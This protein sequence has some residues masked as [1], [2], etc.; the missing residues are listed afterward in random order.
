MT[1]EFFT[2]QEAADFLKISVSLLEAFAWRGTGPA[3]YKIGS[4]TTRYFKQDLMKWLEAY[5]GNKHA[6]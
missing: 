4:R 1:D 2:R 3:F 5:K 6:K